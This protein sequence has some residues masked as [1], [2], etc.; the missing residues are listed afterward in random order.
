MNNPAILFDLDGT[1]LP[2]NYDEFTNGYFRL[3]CKK[4]APLDYPADKLVPAIWAGVKAIIQGDGSTTGETRFWQE[5]A[6]VFGDRVYT[7]KPVV[8]SF[9]D[10]EFNQANVYTQPTPLART[11]VDAAQEKGSQVILATNPIFPRNGIVSRLNWAGLKET[12]FDLITSYE[13]SHYCKPDPRYYTEILEKQSLLPE[14][15]V[16][17]GNDV[18]ED[19][20][21]AQKLGIKTFL[22]KDCLIG[23]PSTVNTDQGN[24]QDAINWVK[25]L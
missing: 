24:I 11:L 7:D 6:K 1:L 2:M 16:M 18:K 12:D 22:I 9:Y 5:F 13:N 4:M 15:C 8:D 10:N 25:N 20:T 14:H 21:A 19:V 3:L 23:D 17:I